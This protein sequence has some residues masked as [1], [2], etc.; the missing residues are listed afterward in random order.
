MH[1]AKV[2]LSRPPI[3]FRERFM[4]EALPAGTGLAASRPRAAHDQGSEGMQGY[5]V[6]ICLGAFLLFSVQL[7]LGKYFL[8]WFGGTPAM[9]TTCMFFFQVLLLAGYGYAHTLV[10]R[11]PS[12]AQA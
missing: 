1:T 5:L 8:P 10:N 4:A 11:F 12:G 9:W 6:A 7:L 3:S 2:R